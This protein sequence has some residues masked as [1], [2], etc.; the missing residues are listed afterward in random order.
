M[1][2]QIIAV[3]KLKEKYLKRACAEYLKRLAPYARMEMIEVAE[4]KAN[5]PVCPSQMERILEKEGE[6]IL[7]YCSRDSYVIVLAIEGRSFTST[8][9]ARKMDQ[10]ATYGKSHLAFVTGGSYGLSPAV[11]KRANLSLSLSKMT[12]PHQLIR[13]FLLEQIYRSFKII[14]GETY[15]K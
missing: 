11:L 10:L 15:H 3:G 12:F 7:R 14:R 9:F 4:E 5:D 2:I 6:R 13:L 1:K 8:E